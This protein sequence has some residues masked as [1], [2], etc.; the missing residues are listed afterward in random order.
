MN[1]ARRGCIMM[2]ELLL[3]PSWDAARQSSTS[4]KLTGLANRR[5]SGSPDQD[6]EPGTARGLATSN[7]K[8]GNALRRSQTSARQRSPCA[9]SEDLPR[10]S[11]GFLKPMTFKKLLATALERVP[12]L[13]KA[14][15]QAKDAA[16]KP[17]PPCLIAG[18]LV[19]KNNQ[20][21]PVIDLR[22]HDRV[23]STE[24]NAVY[25]LDENA[26][27]IPH[28]DFATSWSRGTTHSK[29]SSQV[30]DIVLPLR[31]SLEE[32]YGGTFKFFTFRRKIWH[33]YDVEEVPY[34]TVLFDMEV[35]KGVPDGAKLRFTS[36]GHQYKTHSDDVVFI[37]KRVSTILWTHYVS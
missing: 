23:K 3:R 28:P 10:N 20:K 11:S 21:R 27:W 33:K 17:V 29:E 8:K 19:R 1:F 6:E 26:R 22:Y 34:G 13:P 14:S 5:L 32:V 30:K 25:C 16:T 24:V 2:H 12:S 35:P 9:T 15:T 37:I 4:S 7:A 31:L 36:C 18:H